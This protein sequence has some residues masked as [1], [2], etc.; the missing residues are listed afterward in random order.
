M[1]IL[2][3]MTMTMMMMTTMIMMMIMMVM[4]MILGFAETKDEV[5]WNGELKRGAH[6]QGTQGTKDE[7]TTPH[8][9]ASHFIKK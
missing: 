8:A 4:M 6:T 7:L 1:I 9:A 3:R 5:T 2:R